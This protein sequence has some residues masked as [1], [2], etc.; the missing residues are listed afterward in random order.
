MTRTFVHAFRFLFSASV[1]V[2]LAA[3]AA[4][5]DSGVPGGTAAARPAVVPQVIFNDAGEYD[6]SIQDSTFG[7]G[8]ASASLAQHA[9]GVG[10]YLTATY[11]STSITNAVVLQTQTGLTV[12]GG[13]VAN[14]SSG[15]CTFSMSATFDKKTNVLAGTYAAVHGCAGESGSFSL[16]K[17]CYYPRGGLDAVQSWSRTP[18]Q[19][20]HGLRQC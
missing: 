9:Q 15:V 14:T 13:E 10:G 12:T 3:C 4:N 20:D 7:N 6:G 5:S 19:P 2:A 11:G 18:A 1:V 17:D 16:T 8:S